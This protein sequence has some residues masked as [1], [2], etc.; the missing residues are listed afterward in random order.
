[1]SYRIIDIE[2]IQN[3]TEIGLGVS[4][5][6]LSPNYLSKDQT[7]ENLKNLLLTKIG[8][9]YLQPK[10]GTDL[11][12]AIFEPSTSDIKQ[13]IVNL[14]TEPVN[15]W[16]PYIDIQEID[17]VTAEDDPNLDYTIRISITYSITEFETNTVIIAAEGDQLEFFAE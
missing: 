5:S 16:L 8:E 13:L 17:V 9:R 6:S 11:L 12:Y 4:V 1:M 10:Y 7:Q 14:I 3:N 15:F 2:D